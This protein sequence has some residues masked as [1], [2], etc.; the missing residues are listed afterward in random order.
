MIDYMNSY[1]R[2]LIRERLL[3]AQHARLA[4]LARPAPP[5][6]RRANSLRELLA[7]SA[8]LMPRATRQPCPDT[9]ASPARS[10]GPV[11]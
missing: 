2:D 9:A 7:R 4:D 6:R 5:A 8:R 11:R 1:A 10:L 3:E